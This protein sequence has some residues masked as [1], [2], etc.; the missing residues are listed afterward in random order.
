LG[1][2]ALFAIAGALAGLLIGALGGFVLGGLGGMALTLYN[3]TVLVPADKAPTGGYGFWAILVGTIVAIFGAPLGLLAGGLAGAAWA[4]A[5]SRPPG[6]PSDTHTGAL[7]VRQ[8][9]GDTGGEGG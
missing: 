7:D 8:E 5:R 6:S 1:R 3:N 2:I 4:V 9:T